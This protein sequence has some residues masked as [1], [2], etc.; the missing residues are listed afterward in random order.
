MTYPPVSASRP[1]PTVRL[2]CL[3]V[4][5]LSAL[6]I[7][8]EAQATTPD[9]PGRVLVVYDLNQPDTN[10]NNIGDSEEIARLYAAA[11][12]VPAANL[13]GLPISTAQWY[14]S[15][16]AAWTQLWDDIIQPLQNALNARGVNN[17][18][19]ILLCH[20]LPY[21]FVIPNT[22]SYSTRAIDNLVA[23][24]FSLG[25]RSQHTLPTFKW[26]NP[27]FESSPT[28][29]PDIG[30]FNHLQFTFLGQ[31]LYL[32][33]RLDGPTV[34]AARELIEGARYG[35]RY[36]STLPGYY[37]GFGYVDTRYGQYSST[38]LD[39][40]P[41]EYGSYQNADKCIA[42]GTRMVEGASLILKWEPTGKEIG[43]AGAVFHD[44]TPALTAPQAL[45]YAGWYNY[46]AYHDVWEWIP[47][48]VACDL[49]SNSI[50]NFHTTYDLAFLT[51]AFQRGLTAG[52]GVIAEPY[53]SGHHRPEVMLHYMLQG[54]TWAE[55]ATLANPALGWVC[56]QMGDPL[57]APF[58]AGRIP[59][60]DVTPPPPPYL[61][62]DVEGSGQ[63]RIVADLDT[64][65]TEPDLVTARVDYG[66]SSGLGQFVDH[67]KVYRVRKEVPLTSLTEDALY[68][69]QIALK[70]PAG[71]GRTDGPFVFFS[72]PADPVR[73]HVAPARTEVKPNELFT[74]T[75]VF[76]A[77]PDLKQVDGLKIE[78]VDEQRQITYDVTLLVQVYHST[79][80]TSPDHD[81]V[82][83]WITLPAVLPSGTY[84]FQSTIK[85]G[86]R[87]HVAKGVVVIL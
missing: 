47:G 40:Y 76:A 64:R 81:T 33:S 7:G 22:T 15:G 48:S 21:R 60:R 26:A 83:V 42:Y 1:R 23:A 41:F 36:L 37:N 71:L 50:Q 6:S 82:A 16:S 56:V 35:E 46:R 24:P 45:F 69:F 27:Y 79:F 66:L 74:L 30:R 55:A 4:A 14:Y 68:H 52:A 9:D 53:L 75:F 12:K 78:L 86:T 17:I 18:D 19:T 85:S 29:T 72:T 8:L 38:L 67:D 10:G 5:F 58:R 62:V 31:P 11:R 73:T 77:E 80:A 70:D 2:F 28:R 25:T 57:Y 44:S 32:V 49:N 87:Q 84:T 51:M 65:Q 3:S 34:H 59:A 43:E 20:G 54:F 39:G 63:A 13:L 61:H